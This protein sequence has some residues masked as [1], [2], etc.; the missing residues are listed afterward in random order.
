MPKKQKRVAVL[1]K[2]ETVEGTD[3][4]PTAADAIPL[5]ADPQ[6]T[7]GAEFENMNEDAHFGGLG[8]H[9]ELPPAGE[10]AE[11]TI[12]SW[13][14]GQADGVTLGTEKV[15]HDAL[16]QAGGAAVTV[17]NGIGT[18][19]VDYEWGLDTGEKSVSV[20]YHEDGLL[21]KLLG[22]R[23]RLSLLMEAGRLIKVTGVLRGLHS[24]A[25]A[26]FPALTLSADP[27]GPNV[28]AAAFAL[29]GW[30]AIWQQVQVDFNTEFGMRPGPNGADALLPYIIGDYA[31]TMGLDPE[32]VSVATFD[33]RG[34]W[35]SKE[36]L[37]MS[38][39]PIGSQAGNRIAASAPKTQLRV[40]GRGVRNLYRTFDLT[41]G[42][43][44][45]TGQDF[46]KLTY[47]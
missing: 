28:A 23:A 12:E 47:T 33:V 15:E 45:V 8:R 14:R 13:L 30:A 31:P 11:L 42:V 46:F 4:V 39:G 36:G 7:P 3:A 5:A 35:R 34:K 21:H 44:V 17:D 19:Q 41:A 20:Y 29:G 10:F 38:L 22:A 43:K 26:A 24:E 18:E 32:V 25:D 9:D 27:K 16:F 1:A 6:F 40:P 37:A 2:I